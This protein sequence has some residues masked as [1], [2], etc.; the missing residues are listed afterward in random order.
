MNRNLLRYRLAAIVALF[1]SLLMPTVAKA[2]EAYAV[3]D[4]TTLT[5]YYDDQRANHTGTV[6]DIGKTSDL[7]EIKKVIFDTSFKKYAPTSTAEW[8][9]NCKKLETIEGIKNLNTDEVTNMSHMFC[10]CYVLTSLDVS[11]FNTEKVTDMS[12][13]FWDCNSLTSLDVSGFKT[14]N[15]TNMLGMFLG[16]Q[17][18]TTLNVSNFNTEKVTNMDGM[19]HSCCNMT[20]LDLSNFNTKNVTDMHNMFLFCESLTTLD[21]SNF[22]TEKVTDMSNMFN[23]C[24]ELTTLHITN[25]STESV[26]DMSWM[27]T[28]CEALATIYCNNTWTCDESTDML[29]YGCTSLVGAVSYDE[30]KTDVSMANP[31][32][33]YFTTNYATKAYVVED[34]AT[35]TFYYDDLYVTRTGTVYG[36]DKTHG[37]TPHP[38]WAGTDRAVYNDKITKVVFDESFK[39]YLPTS[40]AYWFY[41]CRKI[42]TIEGIENL[43]TEKVTDMSNMFCRCNALTSLD[44]T[45]FITDNV[46]DMSN[47]F[48]NCEALTS[49]DVTG[50]NTDNV[51]NM[52]G[53]FNSCYSLTSLDV[54]NFNTEKVTDMSYM[55]LGCNKLTSLDVTCFITDNVTDMS[56]MFHDC[57]LLT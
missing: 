5:F 30:N 29:F 25:F 27:F 9:Y 19:F 56:Y 23:G 2:Q 4:G 44:V 39:T 22:N 20:T 12:Y 31:N 41:N 48:C 55:F 24:I 16:C 7:I 53:M 28:G 8:F 1:I 14:N 18:L 50:F 54:S 43:N 26:T 13:M 47:L 57:E 51:T 46:T 11:G 49:I 40:T 6:R 34:D 36:I 38:I 21:L 37:E 17:W 45:G 15:V 32:T 42:E 10:N 52:A 33:G 3:E 35:L